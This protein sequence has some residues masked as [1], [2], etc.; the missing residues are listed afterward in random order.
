MIL[1]NQNFYKMF[2]Q[3]VTLVGLEPAPSNTKSGRLKPP[4][5]YDQSF[6]YLNE[7]KYNYCERYHIILRR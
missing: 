7:K 5:H 6:G 1:L 2:P 4:G 3:G